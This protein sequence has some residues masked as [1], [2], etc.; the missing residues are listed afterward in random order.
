MGD[1]R[2]EQYA[3]LLVER[4]LNVQPG[5]QVLIRTTPL[6]RPLVEE[7]TRLIA[8]RG[9]YALL[10]MNWTLFPID[11]VWAAAAPEALLARMPDIDLYACDHMDAR[12]TI[13]APENTREDAD[14]SPERHALLRHFQKAFF[15]RTMT[16]EIPWVG[17]QF[18]TDALAQEAGLTLRQFE[19]LLFEACLVDWDAIGRSMQRYLE[20]FD[21][22]REVRL[23]GSGTD[24]TLSLEG[25]NGEIDA[26]LVNMPGGEFYFSPVE[27]SAEG[28]IDFSEFPALFE[29]EEFSGVRLVFREGRVVD[30]A[31]AQGE[32]HLLAILDRDE[33]ARRIGELGIGCNPGIQRY[34]RNTLFDEKID[35]TAH[36]ALGESYISVGGKNVSAIHW[37]IVKDLRNGGRIELDGEIVQENGRWLD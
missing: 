6:A 33:G 12:I 20:R 28:S 23:V 32:A 13:E 11:N 7:V 31:A 37:D 25:R 14:L 26:G 2:V 19:D 36:I 1:P 17:C 29:G 4:S 22:A 27:E 35:G 3:K 21:A 24:L 30:A 16:D 34:M 10:R 9:A 8:G 15:R 5:W 18:P